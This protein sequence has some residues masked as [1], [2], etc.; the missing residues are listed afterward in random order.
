MELTKVQ[1]ICF[2]MILYA[3]NAR[4]NFIEAFRA[5]MKGKEE[6]AEALY[7]QGIEELNKAHRYEAEFMTMYA[8]NREDLEMDLL[9]V[10]ANDH[11]SMALV[12]QDFYKEL[13]PMAQA[14]NQLKSQAE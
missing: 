4:Q 2:Q 10:H 11:L 5:V 8:Q 3:G 6:E 13:K 12:M 7:E 9:L 14:V 1:E